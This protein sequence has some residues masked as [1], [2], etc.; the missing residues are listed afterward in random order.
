MKK[1][2]LSTLFC[3]FALTISIQAQ[4]NVN[5]FRL[6]DAA[7]RLVTQTGSL[8]TRVYNDFRNS[9]SGGSRS[10]LE[11]VFLAQ[12]LDASA[13]LFQQMV[14]DRRRD[15]E[16]RDAASILLDLS[17]RAPTFGSNSFIWRD[18]QTAVHNIQRE[19][20]TGGGYEPPSSRP[21]SGRV[22]WRGT[23]DHEIHLVIQG[24]NLETRVLQ[25]TE[26]RN[27]TFNFTSAL[28]SRNVTVEVNKKS[29]R[30]TATVIQQP[31]RNNNYTAIIRVFDS[32]SGAREYDLDIFWY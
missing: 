27:E 17:R 8:S 7:N 22:A 12:Q 30:G 25:G 24:R 20:G 13:R 18:V 31:T 4:N 26:Y 28:P 11:T 14:S 15:S 32:G 16:L 21:V 29:G 19:V 1:T 3:L 9:R 2:F 23:V 10:D 5:Y 6:N